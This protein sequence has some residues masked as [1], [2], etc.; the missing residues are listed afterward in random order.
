[1]FGRKGGIGSPNPRKDHRPNTTHR[2]HQL[3]IWLLR[4]TW[5]HDS[6][7]AERLTSRATGQRC[8]NY[9]EICFYNAQYLIIFKI[10]NILTPKIFITSPDRSLFL[11]IEYD[12]TL[13][14]LELSDETTIIFSFHPV[15]ILVQHKCWII[16]LPTLK[17]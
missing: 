9:T 6:T 12:G 13:F 17:Y 11:T 15:I 16:V 3:N 4:V 5:G 10:G 2:Q 1:M 7:G 14:Q 8:S